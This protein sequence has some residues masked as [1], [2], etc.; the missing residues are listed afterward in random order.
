MN[1]AIDVCGG[2]VRILNCVDI[3]IEY[4][5]KAHNSSLQQLILL[6]RIRTEIVDNGKFAKARLKFAQLQSRRNGQSEGPQL[7]YLH[8]SLR[9]GSCHIGGLCGTLAFQFVYHQDFSDLLEHQLEVVDRIFLLFLSLYWFAVIHLFLPL[10]VEVAQFQ[11]LRAV[12]LHKQ[13]DFLPLFP[14]QLDQLGQLSV[15]AAVPLHVLFIVAHLQSWLH[16]VV[17]EGLDL[18]FGAVR[19]LECHQIPH[20]LLPSV[21]TTLCDFNELLFILCR[22]G[23]ADCFLAGH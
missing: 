23:T 1:T 14:V 11:L 2:Q 5:Q 10:Q 6:N 15:V 20:Y 9:R 21:Y 12:H 3:Y 4:L 19:E 18:A 8:T 22:P 17:E 16:H 13:L 7:L